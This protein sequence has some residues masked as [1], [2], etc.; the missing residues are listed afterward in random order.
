MF[1]LLP[2]ERPKENRNTLNF[3]PQPPIPG[4]VATPFTVA[5]ISKYERKRPV[6]NNFCVF[7]P[8]LLNA[9]DADLQ[10]NSFSDLD[11]KPH[12]IINEEVSPD[13]FLSF[14]NLISA[15]LFH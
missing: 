14:F 4:A 2:T 12:Q 15:P 6:R 9:A 11:N 5:G 3:I 13:I 1:R 10:H 7:P 8:A